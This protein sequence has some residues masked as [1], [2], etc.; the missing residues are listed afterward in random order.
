MKFFLVILAVFSTIYAFSITREELKFCYSHDLMEI[1]DKHEQ[2]INNLNIHNPKDTLYF[3]ILLK[4]YQYKDDVERNIQTIF[5]KAESH[6]DLTSALKLAEM[7]NNENVQIDSLYIINYLEELMKTTFT[8]TIDINTLT[9]YFPDNKIEK[10]SLLFSSKKYNLILE[11]WAKEKADKIAVERNDN[12]RVE[13]SEEFLKLCGKSKEKYTIFNI[14]VRSLIKSKRYDDA[15]SRITSQLKKNNDSLYSFILAE[16]LLD[17]AFRRNLEKGNLNEL[18]LVQVHKLLLD[19]ITKINDSK[20]KYLSFRNWDKEYFEDKIYLS[21]LKYYYYLI[22][23][24]RNLYGDESIE[25]TIFS[26]KEKEIFKEGINYFSKINF[27]NNDN[28][29]IAQTSLWKGRYNYL[30]LNKRITAANHFIDCLIA[31]S[32]RNK[33]QKEAFRMLKNIH[34]EIGAKQGLMDW[35]RTQ[36]EYSGIVFEKINS[37]SSNKNNRISIGDLNNDGLDDLCTSAKNIYI[38]KGNFSFYDIIDSTNVY[39]PNNSGSLWIDVDKNGKQDLI[40]FSNS[41]GEEG[42]KIFLNLGD[43]KL[44]AS[45]E[46]IGSINNK[47]IT[48]G[49]AC[50]DED[51]DGF[52]SIYVANYQ[53]SNYKNYDDNLWK[54]K[55]SQFFDNRQ[56]IEGLPKS[57]QAGRGVAP[58]DYDNDGIQE[59]FVTNY[60]L[61]QNFLLDFQDSIFVN[62]AGLCQMD[63]EEVEGYFAHSIG[64]SWGDYDN[65]GD[66]DLFC[67]NLAHPRYINFS[68]KSVLY[69]NDGKVSEVIDG[70]TIE[71]HKFRNVTEEA[72]IKYDELHS[73]PNWFD[74]DN[75]GDLDLFITSIYKNERSYLYENLGDGKFKDITWLSNSRVLNG[76]GTATSDLNNDGFVDLC[77]GSSSGFTILKNVSDIDNAS[78]QLKP[79]WDNENK[80]T[81]EFKSNWTDTLNNTPAFGSKIILT[82]KTF[83]GKFLRQIRELSCGHGTNSQNSQFLHFGIGHGKA[84]KAELMFGNQIVKEYYFK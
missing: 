6:N 26:K 74:A 64:A 84:L 47:S 68:E 54:L 32:P 34:S 1:L 20:T 10:D 56:S 30:K 35:V 57:Y 77:I 3:D 2:E 81:F 51:L 73:E 22:L 59:I 4:L 42:D 63:G 40:V 37:F 27:N 62:V 36:K 58:A 80:V 66:L 17:P 60:R 44:V 79:F 11:K 38:N 52:P 5:R 72:G 18:I 55:N 78:I 82:Y 16:L 75:D 65:D 15:Y 31:G 61:N 14:L 41:L 76:W 9:Y 49:A 71:Y 53:D 50:I 43:N 39:N 29:E 28:G 7:L 45:E 19:S 24:N 25:I 8:D 67:A 23:S 33:Y 12:I 69:R 21:L 83:K 70:E 48:E 13:K 46:K